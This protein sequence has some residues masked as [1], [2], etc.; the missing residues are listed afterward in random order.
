MGKI[1][2]AAMR[3]GSIFAYN[4]KPFY[5]FMWAIIFLFI[6][7]MCYLFA[8]EKSLPKTIFGY[9][10]VIAVIIFVITL[11]NYIISLLLTGYNRKLDKIRQ[12]EESKKNEFE[13]TFCGKDYKCRPVYDAFKEIFSYD[14]NRKAKRVTRIFYV[15]K[16]INMITITPTCA[17]VRK[18]FGSDV[19]GSG[20]NFSDTTTHLNRK[21]IDDEETEAIATMLTNTL[22]KIEERTSIQAK[23]HNWANRFK[24]Y[25]INLR[26]PKSV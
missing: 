24:Q 11:F 8:S 5:T 15:A 13:T 20:G 25:I 18:Y 4:D 6:V 14:N 19:V 23:P 3:I 9:A 10:V 2:E 17:V 16:K 1:K 26:R 12:I 7:F 22:E 21:P